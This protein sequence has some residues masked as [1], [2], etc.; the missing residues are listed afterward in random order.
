MPQSSPD[1]AI[2]RPPDFVLRLVD[3]IPAD[4]AVV[5]YDGDDAT[6]EDSFARINPTARWLAWDR[7]GGLAP[8]TAGAVV[9]D[10]PL[11]AAPA[12]GAVI[13]RAARLL[14]PGGTLLVR[15][16]NAEFHETVAS[17]L[18]GG[19][20]S[21][22]AAHVPEA[23]AP[24]VLGSGLSMASVIADHDDV[25]GARAFAQARQADLDRIGMTAVSR[26]TR[27]A[28]RSFLVVALRGPLPPPMFINA[29]LRDPTL[30][31]NAAMSE[32]RVERPLRFLASYPNLV[33]RVERDP[34]PMSPP[35]RDR[36][37]F[38]HQRPILRRPWGLDLLREL[39]RRNYVVVLEFDDH[40]SFWPDIALHDYLTFAGPHAV[41]TST[42]ALADV[43]RRYNPN[44]AVFRNDIA[45]L[46]PPRPPRPGPVRVFYGSLNRAASI[47]PLTEGINRVLRTAKVATATAVILDREFFD[48]LE[49]PRKSYSGMIDQARHRT[50]VSQA[51]I[52]LLPLADTEFNRCKSD[53]SFIE[54]AA[55][56][57]VV[58]AS[59]VVYGSSVV[60]GE[61]GFL[62][63]SPAEFEEKFD[64]LIHDTALRRRLA[65]NAYAYVRRSR[66]LKDSF[67]ER[68]AWYQSLLDRKSELDAAAAE[69]VPELAA[70]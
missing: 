7:A 23:V 53:L 33:I 35:G 51:D 41:Q 5:V 37:I 16:T 18:D 54:A 34:A 40:P 38:I 25:A 50:L 30:G 46:P 32:V 70:R 20:D 56:G 47:E 60:D 68:Y 2:S 59:P 39:R 3:R 44:V 12:A 9:L 22:P 58:I 17:R 27:L 63:R 4:A 69:R 29:R 21:D 45:E 67:R 10:R 52:V 36:S 31:A 62:Y 15:C 14:A 26:L 64:R 6:I 1:K 24:L 48:R 55:R 57:A 19:T 13:E 43:L 8:G 28:G 61:T 49:T 11:P 42:P 65:A 66:L